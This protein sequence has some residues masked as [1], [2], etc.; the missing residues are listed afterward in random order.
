MANPG[1]N[2]DVEN[3]PTQ[4]P[5]HEI[6]QVAEKRQAEV[7]EIQAIEEDGGFDALAD[8]SA[9]PSGLDSEGVVGMTIEGVRD[10]D[11]VQVQRKR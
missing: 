4:N 1:Q 6:A 10:G 8:I 7:E 9:E 5:E 2:G 11:E 3:D